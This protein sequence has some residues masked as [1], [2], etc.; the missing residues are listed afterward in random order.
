MKSSN[1]KSHDNLLSSKEK[2]ISRHS[3]QESLENPALPYLASNLS[4]YPLR[5]K[6]EYLRENDIDPRSV[7]SKV[8][9]NVIKAETN[10]S[11]P[12]EIQNLHLK[13]LLHKQSL[14]V[15]KWVKNSLRAKTR[16]DFKE[17]MLND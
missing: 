10:L 15:S 8:E 17:F 12:A 11:I 4:K 16:L 9:R 14:K 2:A 13:P 6:L 7:L 1:Q 5:D 3:S